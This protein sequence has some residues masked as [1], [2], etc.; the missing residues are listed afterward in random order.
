MLARVAGAQP[1]TSRPRRHPRTGAIPRLLVAPMVVGLLA[2][3]VYPLLYLLVLSASK[4]LL[5]KPFQAWVGLD[6]YRAALGDEVFIGSLSRS[7]G[8][9]LPITLIQLTLGFGVALLLQGSIRGGNIVRTLLLLPLMTPP[10]MVAIAWKLILHPTG[11]LANAMLR[12]LGLTE[13]PVSFLG[14]SMLAF[15]S[16][17]VADTWQWTPF[18]ILLAFAALQAI[19]EE[20]HQTALVDGASPWHAF[21]G[22]TLPMVAPALIAVG[23]IRLIMAFK[24]FDLVYALTQGG[25]GFDTTVATFQIYRTALE[26]FDVGSAAAQTIIF[27]VVV[28]LVILPV[29]ILRDWA[30]RR[31]A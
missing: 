13:T 7:V 10:I 15:P 26:R 12:D 21:W 3:A 19:P 20:T 30:L 4:S 23:L 29:V 14:S 18:V 31:F 2:F 1:P 22:V 6:N 8:F 27:G 25:P 16:I 11:G 5:G 9:A 24:L 17:A 28:S